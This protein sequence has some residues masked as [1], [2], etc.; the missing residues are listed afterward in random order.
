M[1][2]AR[3]PLAADYF[4]GR[5]ARAHPVMLSLEGDSLAIEGEG[6]SRRVPCRQVMWPERTRHGMRVAHL[7]DG[8]SIQCGDA[9]AWDAWTQ[10][11]GHHESFVVK[12]QQSWRWV[13]ASLFVTVAVL[14]AGYQWGLPWAARKS[15]AFIPLSVDESIGE[16]AFA[17]VDGQLMS[18]S[19]LPAEQ[20]AR[21]RTAFERAVATLPPGTAPR[22]Q[23]VFRKSSIGPNAFALPGGTMVL[24]D[25]LVKLVKGDEQVIVGVLGHELGHVRKRHGMRMLAQVSALGAVS[26]LVFGDFNGLLAA[27]PVW[28][29]QASYSR[30][31]EREADVESVRLMKA[32]GIPPS[33]MVKFFELIATYEPEGSEAASAPKAASEP[34]AAKGARRRES[35]WLGI[36]IASHPADEERI[37]FFRDAA[38]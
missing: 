31:A 9:G 28:L 21:I 38:R 8:A 30:D 20:Q 3:V 22:Y 7:S 23:L 6:V 4:D 5:S 13:V 2:D 33:A 37:A 11:G 29:G 19:Q 32:A 25:E 15:V 14:A 17:S 24:T 34:K 36:A 10:A 27:A 1:S 35:S 16:S 26:S 18:P 12:V